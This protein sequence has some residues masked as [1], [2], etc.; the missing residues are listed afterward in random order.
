VPG[1]F[2]ITGNTLA[3]ALAKFIAPWLDRPYLPL[4]RDRNPAVTT[5]IARSVDRFRFRAAK[6]SRHVRGVE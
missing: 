6:E 5:E 2:E 4:L 1:N 3:P